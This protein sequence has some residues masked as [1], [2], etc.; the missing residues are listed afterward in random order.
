MNKLLKIIVCCDNRNGIGKDNHLPWN[1]RSEMNLFKEKTIGKGNNCVIMGKNTFLSI[2]DQ[3]SPLKYRM[4]YIMTKNIDLI[5]R[6]KDNKEIKCL[7]DE[8]ELLNILNTTNYDEYWLIGGESIYFY[9][10]KKYIHLIDEVHITIINK[11]YDCN[12]FF[13]F[14]ESTFTIKEKHIHFEDNYTHY[15]LKNTIY[16]HNKDCL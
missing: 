13:P 16:N 9:Y 8:D 11:N 12:K 5:N 1:I 10:L 15:V 4:N 2:P 14:L 6:F 7:K 3:H